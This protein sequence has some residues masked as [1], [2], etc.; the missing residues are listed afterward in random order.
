MIGIGCL[1]V[2]PFVISYRESGFMNQPNLILTWMFKI[3][4]LKVKESKIRL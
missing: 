1:R 2:A 3:Q 4:V